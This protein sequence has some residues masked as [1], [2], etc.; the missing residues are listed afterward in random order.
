MVLISRLAAQLGVASILRVLRPWRFFGPSTLRHCL[1]TM[2]SP[3]QSKPEPTKPPPAIQAMKHILRS[4]VPL[5]AQLRHIAVDAEILSVSSR[6]FLVIVLSTVAEVKANQIYRHSSSMLPAKKHE[7][8]KK[9]SANLPSLRVQWTQCFMHAE[10]TGTTWHR[11]VL[12]RSLGSESR[13][14]GAFELQ[15]SCFVLVRDIRTPSMIPGLLGFA[16]ATAE[17]SVWGC[18]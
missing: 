14:P 11:Q 12:H 16:W 7:Q 18:G 9:R 1:S 15:A 4:S 8:Y 2:V 10:G 3:Q 5:A 17:R 6:D 13:D